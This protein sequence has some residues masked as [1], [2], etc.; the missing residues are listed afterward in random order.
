VGTY[1]DYITARDSFTFEKTGV[2]EGFDKSQSWMVEEWNNESISVNTVNFNLLSV[3]PNPFNEKTVI[4]F[5]LPDASWVDLAI[6][7]IS[8]R[9]V[10]SLVTGHWS[11]GKHSV[12]WEA[13]GM[14]SG[15]YF[16]RLKAGDF[17]QVQK[18]VLMK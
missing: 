11:L 1:P 9:E 15:I 3:S 7:D 17:S 18:M 16:V 13:K 10:Q 12:V 4:S 5:Q 8:G 2:T 6:Y 14:A